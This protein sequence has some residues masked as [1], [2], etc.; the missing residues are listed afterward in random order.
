MTRLNGSSPIDS[1]GYMAIILPFM[2]ALNLIRHLKSLDPVSIVANILQSVGLVIVLY[3]VLPG[4]YSGNLNV[5]TAPIRKL[6]LYFGTAM[7]A[8]EG[9]GVVSIFSF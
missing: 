2:I 8:F 3:N 4:P 6:P 9:I 1:T 5:Y 7:Y